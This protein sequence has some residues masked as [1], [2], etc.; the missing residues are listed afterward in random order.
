MHDTLPQK[1]EACSP[2]KAVA[3]EAYVCTNKCDT[4]G[5]DGSLVQAW[6]GS[7]ELRCAIS[8]A[9]YKQQTSNLKIVESFEIRWGYT[10]DGVHCYQANG[11]LAGP[12]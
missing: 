7:L 2:Y 12:P 9:P 4:H 11:F 10:N 8:W 3:C 5:V 6:D 1:F